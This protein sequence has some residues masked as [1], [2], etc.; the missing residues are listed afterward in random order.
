MSPGLKFDPTL[1][2]MAKKYSCWVCNEAFRPVVPCG[3]LRG[4]N[5]EHRSATGANSCRVWQRELSNG[6][7]DQHV[8]PYLSTKETPWTT[9][10][11]NREAGG[12]QREK[13]NQI[14]PPRNV[15]QI[16]VQVGVAVYR[17][18]VSVAAL[19]NLECFLEV[20]FFS[21]KKFR[22]MCVEISRV[23]HVTHDNSCRSCIDLKTWEGSYKSTIY[24]WGKGDKNR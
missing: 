6:R 4:P 1:S 18:A 2:F 3:G 20:C 15:I 23:G 17:P 24:I 21:L 12:H 7:Y 10:S 5:R 16:G 8:K 13:Q 22:K 19:P 14:F 11:W 9:G